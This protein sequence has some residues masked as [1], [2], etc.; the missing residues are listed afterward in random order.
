M[1]IE[2]IRLM[3]TREEEIQIIR[4]IEGEVDLYDDED[5]SEKL[6]EYYM[7]DMPYGTQK[8]RDGDPYEW[9]YEHLVTD[10][11]HLTKVTELTEDDLKSD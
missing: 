10:F 5:L 9:I 2:A 3:F 7:D 11:D 1:G 4:I 6:Y 8:A